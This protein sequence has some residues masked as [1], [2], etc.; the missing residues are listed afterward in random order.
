MNPPKMTSIMVVICPP[1]GSEETFRVSI[2]KKQLR[3]MR[4]NQ[5]YCKHAFMPLTE[6]MCETLGISSEECEIEILLNDRGRSAQHTAT[7]EAGQHLLH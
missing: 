7:V 6:K 1:D 4:A 3:D 5:A 2:R